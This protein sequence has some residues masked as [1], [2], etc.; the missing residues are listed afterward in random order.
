MPQSGSVLGDVVE[1]F[2]E[3]GGKA[4]KEI[5]KTP[6]DIVKAS[7]DQPIPNPS[8]ERTQQ[9]KDAE[10]AK[11]AKVRS[12]LAMESEMRTAPPQEQPR[13]QQGAEITEKGQVSNTAQM[14]NQLSASMTPKKKPEPLVVQ[15]TRKNKL[16]GAG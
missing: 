10:K 5:I 7:F 2:K 6:L 15:Q 9:I 11:L 13:I 14:N 16:Q 3:H 1:T 12:G 8:E 4:V